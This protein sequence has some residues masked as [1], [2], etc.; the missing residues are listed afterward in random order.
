MIAAVSADQMLAA[1]AFDSRERG[2]SRSPLGQDHTPDV[3]EPP[4]LL[5]DYCSAPEPA[6]PAAPADPSPASFTAAILCSTLPQTVANQLL[7]LREPAPEDSQAR[8][9]D[10]L[11]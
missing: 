6:Q 8:L 11:V 5:D 3:P 10:L 4:Q 1:S 7:G 9:K 2:R